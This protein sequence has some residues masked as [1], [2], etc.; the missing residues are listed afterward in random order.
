MEDVRLHDLRRTFGSWLAT[1]GTPL[2]HIEKL[3]NHKD[4]KTTEV[5]AHLS[6]DPLREAIDKVG[7]KIIQEANRQMKD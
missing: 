7:E 6:K 1:Q 4:S 2:Y 5:Y 3:L